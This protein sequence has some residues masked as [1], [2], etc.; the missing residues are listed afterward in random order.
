MILFEK[1]V[2][3][4]VLFKAALTDKIPSSQVIVARKQILANI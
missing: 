2:P 4:A 3:I 1:H